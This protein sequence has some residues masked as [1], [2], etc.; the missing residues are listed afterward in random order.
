MT[1]GQIP[2]KS[3]IS[4][5]S[6]A[7]LKSQAPATGPRR[8]GRGAADRSLADEPLVNESL[9]DK[10][11]ADKTTADKTP[12]A[13]IPVRK[14]VAIRRPGNAAIWYAP[15]G[16]DPKARGINGRR[17]AGE[18]FLRGFFA[19]GAVEEFVCLCHRETDEAHF[20]AF[21]AR[22]G[23]AAP[24]RGVRLD[25]PAGIAP[26][27]VVSYPSPNF[28]AEAWRRGAEGGGGYAICG[29]THT[30]A[31]RAV[32][33]GLFDL[34]AA[35]QMGWD[36]V[37]CTSRAVKAS[38]LAQMD[39]TDAH[40]A[41]RFG[42]GDAAL[43]PPRPLL[44]VIPLGIDTAAFRRDAAA[45][46]ALRARLGIAEGDIACGIVA[47]LSPSGKF[48]P[49]PLFVALAR[50]QAELKGGARFHLILCGQFADPHGREV[51]VKGAAALMPG[52][53]FHLT[54][55][56]DR[57]ERLAALSASDIFL[58][59]V[60]NV[61]ETFGLAPIEAM[62]A[63]LPVIVS[64]W[65]G[66]KDTVTED[67]GFR[68]PTTFAHG[69]LTTRI[70][71]RMSGGSDSYTQYLSQLSAL[72]VLDLR[73]LTGALLRLAQDP[74]LR[75]RMGRAGQARARSHYDW[76][77]VIPQ[78]QALWAEQSARLAHARASGRL[79]APIHPA[80]V[81]PAPA[82][83]VFFGAYPSRFGPA[84]GAR[85]RPGEAAGLPGVEEAMALRNYLAERRLVAGPER[86]QA[87]R[88]ALAARPEGATL[89]DL[90]QAAGLRSA[91]AARAL[92]WLMKYGY[93]EEV[94]EG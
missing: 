29:L 6:R 83:G 43:L 41:A 4:P 19:H 7:P 40:L 54:D 62:A 56:A 77:A 5:K 86:L 38:V 66:M 91:G 79:P 69:G 46:R 68:V 64:D 1:K 8:P 51:F 48:D 25:R 42:G 88:D 12:A 10:A 94:G 70:G 11:S 74:A 35:P 13:G 75:A 87:L 45:G 16:Y 21:A 23:V 50:A 44:P 33:Q 26:L 32:M 89:A 37:I 78:M 80:R 47:R 82:P 18:S 3:Q 65:D 9:V 2:P 28:A 63:G 17:V 20:R 71:R 85:F 81:P 58:F 39:L 72:T 34:R 84:P 22:E 53:G 67:C 61:Q 60:D 31:T 14:A 55:G 30:T 57:A 76:A 90:A 27:D 49:L 15:D 59:P 36:A 73:E 93:A 52:C 24:L 92:L